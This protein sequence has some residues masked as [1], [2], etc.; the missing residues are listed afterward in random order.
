MASAKLAGPPAWTLPTP[1]RLS[2]DEQLITEALGE[3]RFKSLSASELSRRTTKSQKFEEDIISLVGDVHK[4]KELIGTRLEKQRSD[5][6]SLS[7][8]L[9]ELA[10]RMEGT[11]ARA[12][13]ARMM[14]PPEVRQQSP[15]PSHSDS[16]PLI[17]SMERSSYTSSPLKRLARAALP[18]RSP[19]KRRPA[20]SPVGSPIGSPLRARAVFGGIASP[21]K[22]SRTSSRLHTLACEVMDKDSTLKNRIGFGGAEVLSSQRRYRE[23]LRC[24]D[25]EIAAL[26]DDIVALEA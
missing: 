5:F 19:E 6:G 21:Q 11:M 16:S 17:Q 10:T 3:D 14:S 12:R 8:H 20:A 26:H 2:S 15:S 24:I 23:E 9:E 22:S 25:T 7:T 18:S 13:A 1:R 4:L